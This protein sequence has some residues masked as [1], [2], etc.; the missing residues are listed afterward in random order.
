MRKLAI[1]I[2]PF[3]NN[4]WLFILVHMLPKCRDNKFTTNIFRP[5]FIAVII[6]IITVF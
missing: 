3:F 4:Y 5:L 1:P 2:D 6:I